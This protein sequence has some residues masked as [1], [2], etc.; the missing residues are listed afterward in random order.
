MELVQVP[1]VFV[2]EFQLCVLSHVIYLC[3]DY[4]FPHKNRQGGSIWIEDSE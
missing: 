1:E 4:I 3:G 2:S